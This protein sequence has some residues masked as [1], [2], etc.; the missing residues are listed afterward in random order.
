MAAKERESTE[1]ELEQSRNQIRQL[2]HAS[3]VAKSD[4]EIK[5]EEAQRRYATQM[6]AKEQNAHTS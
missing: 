2:Q 3:D 5:L 6:A 4:L 1:Q